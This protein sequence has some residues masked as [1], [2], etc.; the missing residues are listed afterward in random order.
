MRHF[1]PVILEDKEGETEDI[2][3]AERSVDH[4]EKAIALPGPVRMGKLDQPEPIQ[5]HTA[6]AKHCN[7]HHSILN[8]LIYKTAPCTS[9]LQASTFYYL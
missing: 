4:E 6:H 5:Y 7:I 2:D 8:M 3:Q 9:P 1:Y